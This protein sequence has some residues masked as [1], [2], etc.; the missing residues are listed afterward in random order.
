MFAAIDR[1]YSCWKAQT[2]QLRF[3]SRPLARGFE[4]LFYN[5]SPLMFLS[6][7]GTWETERTT[8]PMGLRGRREIDELFSPLRPTGSCSSVFT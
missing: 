5:S 6:S 2:L 1:S 7:C 3:L 4:V 8:T